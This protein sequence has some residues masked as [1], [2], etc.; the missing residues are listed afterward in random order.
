M[1]KLLLAGLLC[2]LFVPSAVAQI[3]D[4]PL[5]IR[6]QTETTLTLAWVPVTG[7]DG[8]DFAVNGTRVSH[9]RDG[10]R[11]SVRFA[12]VTGCEFECYEVT[13]WQQLVLAKGGHPKKKQCS[14]LK[15][16]DGD[17]LVD[18]PTDPGC[19]SAADDDEFNSPPPPPPAICSDGADN[20]G[21]GKIDYPADPG[22]ASA[23]DSDET[24][25]VT[26]PPT[27]SANLWV[28]SNGGTCL[29]SATPASYADGAACSSFAA[30]YSAASS[31]DV[32]GV[33]G[34]LGTQKFAG[35]FQ[36][37]QPSGTKTL[38]F[39][40][41][42]SWV[43]VNGRAA[44]I[45]SD[46]KVNQI[47]FGSPNLT[48]DGI[49][50]DSSGQQITGAGFENGGRPFT[51]K[52]GAIGNITN[53][54]GALTTGAGIIYDNVY[55][56]DV[57]L[58]SSS[59][60]NE[61]IWT[62][63]PQGMVI[64]NSRFFNCATMDL[65]FTYPDYWTPLPEPYGNVTLENTYFDTPRDVGGSPRGYTLYIGRNGGVSMN[66]WRVVNNTFYDAPGTTFDYGI[67]NG[68][69][70]VGSGNVFCGNIGRADLPSGWA[71]AC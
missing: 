9:T 12:K 66:G 13:A 49:N 35:G 7:A 16:N 32:V 39:K 47:H 24:D 19:T 38:T 55:F 5:T 20:D 42:T 23:T 15:D 4:L 6:A 69:Q 29:R 57:T 22:C 70:A 63:E 40:G 1:R 10:T 62:A 43:V 36:S 21:D 45:T 30:A 18:Y 2:L 46:N 34:T 25:P 50:V 8:Y 54:K 44:T 33:R 31:G 26:P 71:A 52:N 64:R 41:V 68:D 58:T 14:D 11:S 67:Y 3:V 60:H 37:S 17:G 48:F 59:V 56:H 61:C 65:F 27:G 28:D 53:E 51:F